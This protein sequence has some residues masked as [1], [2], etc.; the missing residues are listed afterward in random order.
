MDDSPQPSAHLVGACGAG[1]KAL[2]E[3]LL[4]LNWSLSGSDLLPPN[5]SMRNLIRRGFV[6]HQGHQTTNLPESAQVLIYSPAIPT[7]NPERQAAAQRQLPQFSYGQ[8]VGR[9]MQESMGVC[10]AGTHGKSTTTAMTAW[11]LERAR[12]LSAVVLGAELCDGRRS[13]WSGPGD[14][15]VAE[16]CEF[17]RSFLDF[18]PK[19]A[20]VLSIETDHFDCYPDLT[21]VETAFRDF[22][23]GIAND[24]VLVVN[25]DCPVSRRVSLS[26]TTR[27]KRVSFGSNKTADW[28]IVDVLSTANGSRFTLSHRGTQVTDIEL[29]L[30]GRHN[31]M[32]ALAAA[33][34]CSE[35]GVEREIIRDA[36]ATFRG[37]RRRFEFVGDWN[38]VTFI[39]DYAHHPTA[40][41]VTLETLRH[42]VGQRRIV[43]VFQ[44]HQVSRTRALMDDFS[45]SFAHAD[46]VILAPV[47]AARESVTS[48]PI[49]V[50]A[51]LADRISSHGV[52]ARSFSSLDQI[53]R[54]LEDASCPGDVIVTMGAGDIDRIH[55][56]F[57][58]RVQ[59]DSSAG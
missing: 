52:K 15:F 39:D 18:K 8:M 13:G 5:E 59:T 23:N 21:S 55:Y 51:E 40:V 47:F 1:M 35:I 29:K 53:V 12:R 4:D 19:Y 27:A 45:T 57:T 32:N 44:P 2:V 16:S 34:M 31:V 50:S 33:A 41:K 26:A 22:A 38:G 24:G 14:L 7:N 46:E 48:E 28:L 43:C 56:E 9:L 42:V 20:A 54:T 25:D 30:H 6:F 3:V 36:L 37:I 58:R 17:Q 49:V 10:I 11:I